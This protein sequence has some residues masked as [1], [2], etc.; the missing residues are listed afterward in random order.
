MHETLVAVATLLATLILAA[1]VACSSMPRAG[2]DPDVEWRV[3]PDQHGHEQC[4]CAIVGR[5]FIPDE[6]CR[7]KIGDGPE[8]CG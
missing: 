3:Y 6:V 4:R 2:P 5:G 7:E 8:A 1:L